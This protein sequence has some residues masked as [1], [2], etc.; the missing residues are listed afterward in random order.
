MSF[1]FLKFICNIFYIRGIILLPNLGLWNTIAKATGSD[2]V[3]WHEMW[4]GIL[5][6]HAEEEEERR[7]SIE[8]LQNAVVSN[9]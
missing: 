4:N 9:L 7:N 1:R 6:L 8:S 3:T 5:D 2:L